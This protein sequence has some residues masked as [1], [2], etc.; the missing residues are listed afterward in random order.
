MHHYNIYTL[1]ENWQQRCLKMGKGHPFLGGGFKYFL[2]SGPYLGKW[3]NLTNIYQMGWNHQLDFQVRTVSF[4]EG[5]LNNTSNAFNLDL[6]H[7]TRDGD[8]G[9]SLETARM[10]EFFCWP[11]G[12]LFPFFFRSFSGPGK[13]FWTIPC[14][15]W[16]E[17]KLPGINIITVDV[18]LLGLRWFF[19]HQRVPPHIE[20]CGRRVLQVWSSFN[21]SIQIETLVV[22]YQDHNPSLESEYLPFL[23]AGP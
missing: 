4:R 9:F 7:A 17:S 8:A 1:L 19:S 2:F 6:W 23:L 12:V 22:I 20:I 21:I 11:S 3:S 13:S 10:P 16:I 15:F 14:E 5:N 18:W